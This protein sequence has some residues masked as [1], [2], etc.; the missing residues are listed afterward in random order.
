MDTLFDILRWFT[1]GERQYMPSTHCLRGDVLWVG[2]TIF[3]SLLNLMGYAIIA[4]HWHRCSRMAAESDAK[5]SL[6]KLKNIFIFCGLCGYLFIVVKMWWPAWRLFDIMMVV[7][8]GWT[9][10]Y[11]LKASNFKVIFERLNSHDEVLRIRDVNKQLETASERL[12]DESERRRFFMNAINHDLRT[13][14]NSIS[15]NGEVVLASIKNGDYTAA[16]ESA[17]DIVSIARSAGDLLNT[18]LDFAATAP[19]E[20]EITTEMLD[21]HAVMEAVARRLNQNAIRK[22]LYLRVIPGNTKLRTDRVKLERI[23]SNLVENGLKFTTSGG[24]EL[25]AQTV[26]DDVEVVVSDTGVGISQDEQKLLFQEF[27][28]VNNYARDSTK[29]FGLGLAITRQLARQLGGDV[30]LD[31]SPGCG[32]RFSVHFYGAAQREV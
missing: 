14:L 18:M 4:H 10:G 26:G 13:P 21:V 29:G 2:I 28:Q 1:G 15:L 8:N 7:L 11:A 27:Y 16:M 9:W 17:Y 23:L 24:V 25:S 30:S 3:L 31:S 22:G 19:T 32:S 12:R 5:H 6:R 20:S